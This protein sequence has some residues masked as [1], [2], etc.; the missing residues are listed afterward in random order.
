M[1]E[2]G[3]ATAGAKGI[4]I[5]ANIETGQ[6]MIQRWKTD[7]VFWGYTGNWIMQEAILATGTV[8]VF[9]AD[10]N[11]SLPLDPLYA[12][13][14]KFRLLPVSDL[15]AFEGIDERLNYVPAEAREQAETILAMGIENYPIRAAGRYT[16]YRP[17]HPRGSGRV[18]TGEYHGS[19]RRIS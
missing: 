13:R 2:E 5:I 18:L 17:S 10:M 15:V 3:T 8:D 4:R 11:C 9:V 14:Y 12:E 6:E 16:G 19:P 1:A 7:D